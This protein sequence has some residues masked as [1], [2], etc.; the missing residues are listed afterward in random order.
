M[1]AILKTFP[2]SQALA[3]YIH[4]Q[5]A[6]AAGS[7]KRYPSYARYTFGALALHLAVIASSDDV[8]K[9]AGWEFNYIE[10]HGGIDRELLEKLLS[11]QRWPLEDKQ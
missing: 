3:I 11:R 9:L 8:A 5:P 7:A 1:T 4:V 2:N 6:L 10:P